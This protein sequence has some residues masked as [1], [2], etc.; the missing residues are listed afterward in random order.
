MSDDED[1]DLF[2]EDDGQSAAKLFGVM[3]LLDETSTVVS[4]ESLSAML[5]SGP[6]AISLS[7]QDMGSAGAALLSDALTRAAHPSTTVTLLSL[8]QND[9]GDDGLQSLAAAN[10]AKVL[11]SLEELH[12]S[13]NGIG[14]AGLASFASKLPPTLTMCD[15]SG[16]SLGDGGL[17]A[18]GG[19][20]ALVT[21]TSL[22]R[23]Y[24][25]RI[26]ARDEGCAALASA[27]AAGGGQTLPSL[28]E[29]WLSNNSIGDAGAVALFDAIGR[30]AMPTLGD[31][32]L[33]YNLLGDP[34]VDALTAAATGGAC[35]TRAWYLGLCDNH[36]TDD[37]LSTLA[38][39]IADGALPRLEFVTC[40]GG[41]TSTQ[42]ELMVQDALS[43]RKGLL[44]R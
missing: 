4:A 27:A 40:S 38:A 36:I 6:T 35:L 3:H 41:A 21:L 14:A 29:L 15:L 34:S 30:G 11:P 43:R 23:L 37:A 31:L 5:A 13:S 2:A 1:D 8:D 26:D 9:I 44:S 42:G 10:P 17:S 24:L 12:L 39:G 16:N 32:R 22:S 33:Q 7:K 19:A 20:I 25:D 28:S 18:L